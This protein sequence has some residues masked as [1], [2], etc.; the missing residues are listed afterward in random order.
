MQ[1]MIGLFTRG[2]IM[3][4]GSEARMAVSSFIEAAVSDAVEYDE[5]MPGAPVVLGRAIETVPK[6][7]RFFMLDDDISHDSS[8]RICSRW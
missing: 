4:F 6:S 1:P 5:R 7:A 3:R 8:F 2:L